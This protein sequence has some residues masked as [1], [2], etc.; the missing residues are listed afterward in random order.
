MCQISLV[1]GHFPN[2]SVMK[3]RNIIEKAGIN[4]DLVWRVILEYKKVW[5]KRNAF[6]WLIDFILTQDNR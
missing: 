3:W 5:M 6:N 2:W 1:F 4:V